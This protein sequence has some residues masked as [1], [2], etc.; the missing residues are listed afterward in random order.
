VLTRISYL[1]IF[2][3]R[4]HIATTYQMRSAKQVALTFALVALSCALTSYAGVAWTGVNL[5]GGEF[6]KP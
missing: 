6:G 5:S 1:F 2:V 4:Q 3:F